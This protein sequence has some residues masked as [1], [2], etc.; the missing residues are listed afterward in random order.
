MLEAFKESWSKQGRHSEENDARTT[1][2]SSPVVAQ[3]GQQGQG[4]DAGVAAGAPSEWQPARAQSP[5]QGLGDA[6]ALELP[7]QQF[8]PSV[9]FRV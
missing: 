7:A 2:G 1:L 4:A 9:G 3:S 8:A 6:F 5:D